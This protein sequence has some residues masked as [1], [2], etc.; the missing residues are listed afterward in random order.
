MNS[1]FKKVSLALGGAVMCLA[2]AAADFPSQPVR[3]VVPLGAGSATDIMARALAKQ[4]EAEWKQPVIV[5]NRPGAGSVLAAE[6]V[7]KAAPDGYT[8]LLTGP[9][10]VIAPL[11]DKKA[12]FRIDRD[13]A[14]VARVA[15][16]RIAL[17]TNMNVPVSNLKEFAAY[18]RAHP[19]KLNYGGLG[20][21][22][23]IDIGIEV[24]KKGLDMDVTPV[25]Y[26]GAA[27]H[28][29]AL[30]R[31]DIQL[32]W[33]GANV[34]REQAAT[35]KVKILAAVSDKRFADLPDVPTVVE[36]GYTGFIPRVWTGIV[37][38]ARTPQ[39]IQDQIARD[40]NRV[41]AKPEVVQALG[42]SLGND[43]APLPPG[44]FAEEARK[45]S[46]FWAGL[47]KE[48]KIEPQ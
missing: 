13:L 1:M 7:A 45:E 20:R 18:S 3:L 27:E 19:G 39:A 16:L 41:L 15:V 40:V 2:A 47:F 30:I 9:S 25:A 11:I 8:L 23:I 32:V 21:T 48:L 24:L 17:A 38:P 10:L 26:K 35:G 28:N 6:H 4:L 43:P 14:P 46:A 36:A 12:T 22:S 42:G 5:E 31:N 29:V 34:L 33:G 44:Q 37:A